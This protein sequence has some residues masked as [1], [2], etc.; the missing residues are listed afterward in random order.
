MSCVSF[1]PHSQ[2]A[3]IFSITALQKISKLPIME[4]EGYFTPVGTPVWGKLVKVLNNLNPF[5]VL[6]NFMNS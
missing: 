1:M 6:N 2:C 4:G 3:D 5:M